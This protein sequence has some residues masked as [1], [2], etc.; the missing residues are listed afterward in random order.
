MIMNIRNFSIRLLVI[1]VCTLLTINSFAQNTSPEQELARIRAVAFEGRLPE[2]ERSLHSL[3]DSLPGYGDARVLLARVLA[4]QLKY[5]EGL[6]VIERFLAEQ[7]ENEDAIETRGDI[8]RWMAAVA[9]EEEMAD[10]LRL[11]AAAKASQDSIRVAARNELIA[12][13]YFDTFREPYPRLWQVWKAG[14]AHRTDFGKVMGYLNIGHIG[15]G[16]TGETE[17]QLEGEAWPTI[18]PTVYGWLNYAWS[19]GIYFPRH[20]ASAELWHTLGGGWVASAGLNYYH[21][22]R[23]I[24]ITVAGVEKYLGRWWLN[25]KV[26]FYF[27]DSGITNSLFVSAR[28]YFNDTDYLQ[29][30]AG[31]GTAPDEPFNVIVDLERLSATTIKLIYFREITKMMTLRAGA[32]YSCEEHFESLYRNRFEGTITLTRKIIPKR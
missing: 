5:E 20:R 32:G 24:F 12:G 15:S 27:K 17:F 26:Y 1:A 30:T 19:P 9:A 18:S 25:G 22:D 3:L 13:Y 14:A 4:W 10:S 31:T 2:A 21:F 8:L 11:A 29:F 7:P 16:G 6:E 28:R 23:N